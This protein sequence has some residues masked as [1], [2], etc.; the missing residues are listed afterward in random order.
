M[1]PPVLDPAAPDV[2]GRH[3]L[4]LPADVGPDEVEILAV[5]R[6]PRAAWEVDPRTTPAAGRAGR[7][8]V[9]TPGVLRLSRHSTLNGP[10]TV[11]RGTVTALGLPPTVGIVYVV[12]APTERGEPPWP[13]GGDRDGLRRAFPHGLPVRD[14]ERVV[15]WLV[16]AARRLGGGVRIASVRADERAVL[17]VPDPAAAVDLTVWTDIW[18]EPEAALAVARQ[19]A[20]RAE[21]NLPAGDWAGPPPGT[22]Q[23]P[24]PGTEQMDARERQALHVAADERDLAVLRD[25]PPM[26]AYG[27]LADL[28]LDGIIALEV[29]GETSLPPVI[30]AVPWAARGAVTYRVRWEPFELEEMESERPSLAHRVARGRATPLVIALTRAVYRAVGGEITDA[31]DFIVDPADL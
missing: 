7:A 15:G 9:S 22:G 6:F 5:S 28:E 17:L 20:P 21:L 18:L 11:D 13:T 16:A 23:R 2:A 1:I 3:L 30:A 27:V 10:F 31:M 12:A 29:A 19:A 14:E 25:P 8:G 4:V 26:Q 24:V